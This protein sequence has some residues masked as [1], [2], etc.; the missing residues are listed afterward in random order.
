MK[1]VTKYMI[2]TGDGSARITTRYPWHLKA[3]EIAYS[4]VINVPDSWGRLQPGKIELTL[5]DNPPVVE[6]IEPL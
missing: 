4:V 3:N 5:P 2:V 6:G 1:R